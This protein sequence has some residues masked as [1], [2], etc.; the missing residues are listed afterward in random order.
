MPLQSG[1]SDPCEGRTYQLTPADMN[2]SSTWQLCR[3]PST[4]KVYHPILT[5][6]MRAF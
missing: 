1:N 3:Q 5:Q 6:R 4:T 2:I